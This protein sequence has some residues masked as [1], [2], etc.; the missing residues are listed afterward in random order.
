[1]I[2]KLEWHGTGTV[3]GQFKFCLSWFINSGCFPSKKIFRL[4]TKK[5]NY[6]IQ[7]TEQN[8]CFIF[9]PKKNNV[10]K[11]FAYKMFHLEDHF[12]GWWCG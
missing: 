7:F 10:G 9:L 4:L 1:M 3:Q 11:Y 2:S 6:E 5:N 8:H 12:G